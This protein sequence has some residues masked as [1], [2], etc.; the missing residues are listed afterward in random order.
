MFERIIR[1]K[2]AAKAGEGF[3]LFISNEDMNDIIKIIKSFEDSGV[4]I[5]GV[6]VT[7]KHEIKEEETPL[8]ASLVQ[9]VISS[10]V[11]GLEEQKKDMWIKILVPLHPLNNIEITNYFNYEPRF[12]GVFSRKSLPR[13]KDA[14]HAINLDDKKSKGT[15]WVS[16]YIDRNTAVYFYSF[17]I[18]YITLEVLNKF[19]DKSVT[20]NILENKMM[21]LL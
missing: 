19:K 12:N 13:I 15:H 14:A 3:N 16:L 1:G 9:S 10:V 7:V 8:A 4:F 18:E 2:G 11:E 20:R 17:G 5:D 6:T 21:N